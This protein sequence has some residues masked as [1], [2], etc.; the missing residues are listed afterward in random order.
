[1]F[2]FKKFSKPATFQKFYRKIFFGGTMNIS[3]KNWSIILVKVLE[4]WR[5]ISGKLYLGVPYLDR[6]GGSYLESF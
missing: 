5:I 4:E 3:G 6:I 1:M 2:L